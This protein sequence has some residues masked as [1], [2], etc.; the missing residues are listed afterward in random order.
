MHLLSELLF[1]L[2]SGRALAAPAVT[3]HPRTLP[4]IFPESAVWRFPGC[5]D[6]SDAPCPLELDTLCYSDPINDIHPQPHLEPRQGSPT[7]TV[8]VVNPVQT[9]LATTTI[10]LTESSVVSIVPSAIIA[11]PSTVTVPTVVL[12]SPTATPIPLGNF[13]VSTGNFTVLLNA[14]APSASAIFTIPP[15]QG[16]SITEITLPTLTA[17]PIIL[18]TVTLSWETQ[19]ADSITTIPFVPSVSTVTAQVPIVP[20]PAPA[21]SG[22][23]S[24]ITLPSIPATTITISLPSAQTVTA[25]QAWSVITPSSPTIAVI[26]LSTSTVTLPTLTVTL[27]SAAPPPSSAGTPVTI[28]WSP[29]LPTSAPNPVT[30]TINPPLA[31]STTIAPVSFANPS[32]IWIIPL[33]TSSPPPAPPPFWTP[34]TWSTPTPSW[35]P[36]PPSISPVWVPPPSP[37]VVPIGQGR[38]VTIFETSGTQIFT[39]TVVIPDGLQTG[40]AATQSVAPFWSATG[41]EGWWT[42]FTVTAS[43]GVSTPPVVQGIITT[44][45]IDS[46]QGSTRTVYVTVTGLEVDFGPTQTITAAT[47]ATVV[48]VYEGTSSLIVI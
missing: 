34:S 41:T 37:S 21:P 4:S 16:I 20:A 46:L 5:C 36:L 40:G 12:V 9:T 28:T 39:S 31:A 32:T 43:A 3:R 7:A 42:T 45:T 14:T 19:P 13:T 25:A 47:P 44:V 24:T 17:T 30:I 10:T 15:S 8:T 48:T 38:T 29:I 6:S 2:V 35:T 33:S 18:T 11:F 22:S 23:F 1:L 27:N 26:T